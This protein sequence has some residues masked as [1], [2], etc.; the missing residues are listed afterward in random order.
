MTLPTVTP[1][2]ETPATPAAPATRTIPTSQAETVRMTAP[3][4]FPSPASSRPPKR[5]GWSKRTLILVIAGALLTVAGAATAFL[6]AG[7][8]FRQARTDLVTHRVRYERLE[9]NIIERGTLESARNSDIYCTLKAG[10]KG[11]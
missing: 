6:V 7:N 3:S 1:V 10:T 9:L 5:R 4:S 11:G 8:P 2:T